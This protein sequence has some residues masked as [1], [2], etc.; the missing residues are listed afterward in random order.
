M[1]SFLPAEKLIWTNNQIHICNTTEKLCILEADIV[2]IY[3]D[4][5]DSPPE[6]I[7]IVSL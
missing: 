4:L 6:V 7:S 5:L 2:N 1:F 3:A